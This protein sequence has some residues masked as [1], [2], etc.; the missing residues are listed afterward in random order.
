MN[1]EDK[2]NDIAGEKN[3]NPPTQA[4]SHTEPPPPQTIRISELQRL[5]VEPLVA[6]A[7]NLGLKNL[8][9][10]L[11]FQAVVANLYFNSTIILQMFV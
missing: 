1:S 11:F 10:C 2:E 7:K 3:S 4:I 8:G 6:F 9:S 5:G